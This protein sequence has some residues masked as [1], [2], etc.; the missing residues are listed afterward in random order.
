MTWAR[1]LQKVR[2]M[3]FEELYERRHRQTL[4]MAE[5]A[6]MLGITERTFRRWSG[7]YH[8]EGAEELQDRRIGR[9][10]AR[11][12]ITER[13]AANWYLPERFRPQYNNRCMV[14]A[15][16]PGTP[17]SWPC[18][19]ALGVCTRPRGRPAA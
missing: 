15:P 16:E 8:A 2:Q 3:R 14:R 10:A 9:A 6:E 13:A 1:V 19:I 17:G 18:S 12:G 5:A 11:A 4:T 7:R